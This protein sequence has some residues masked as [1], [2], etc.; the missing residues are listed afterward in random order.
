MLIT[1]CMKKLGN[2][3]LVYFHEKKKYS[4][5]KMLSKYQDL[6]KVIF[7]IEILAIKKKE[8]KERDETHCNKT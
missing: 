6:F 3:Y 7:R 1:S 2:V 8:K 4:I 5:C